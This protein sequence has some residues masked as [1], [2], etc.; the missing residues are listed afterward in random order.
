MNLLGEDATINGVELI[1]ERYRPGR[2]A[3]DHL[4]AANSGDGSML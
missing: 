4:F 3:A 1:R 2:P